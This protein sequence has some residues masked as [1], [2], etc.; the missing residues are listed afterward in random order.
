MNILCGLIKQ[1]FIINIA[2]MICTVQAVFLLLLL[3]LHTAAATSTTTAIFLFNW[4]TV[5]KL[6]QVGDSSSR[7]LQA[8]CS[9]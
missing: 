6:I 3:L 9:S 7:F 5:L 2:A 4:S 8:R 1:I